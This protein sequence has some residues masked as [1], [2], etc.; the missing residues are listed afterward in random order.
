MD[1]D[2]LGETKCSRGRMR[3]SLEE[4][5]GGVA[6]V[7]KRAWGHTSSLPSCDKS[8]SSPVDDIPREGSYDN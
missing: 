4:Q 6:F 2:L 7:V 1:I 8:Q 5:V 3:W